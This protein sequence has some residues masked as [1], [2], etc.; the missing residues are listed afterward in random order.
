MSS[1]LQSSPNSAANSDATRPRRAKALLNAYYSLPASSNVSNAASPSS[2]VDPVSELDRQGFDAKRYFDKLVHTGELSQEA[3]AAR[4]AALDLEIQQLDS[5]LQSLV[6]DN[7]KQFTRAAGVISRMKEGIIEQLEPDFDNL[8]EHIKNMT[9]YEEVAESGVESNCIKLEEIIKKQQACHKLE[10]LFGLP[11]TLSRHLHSGNYRSAADIFQCCEPFLRRHREVASFDDVLQASEKIVEELKSALEIRIKKEDQETPAAARDAFTLLR[12]KEPIDKVGR[13]FL[14]GR[15]AVLKGILRVLSKPEFSS[16]VDEKDATSTVQDEAEAKAEAGAADRATQLQQDM[17]LPESRIFERATNIVSSRYLPTLLESVR[18]FS[19]LQDEEEETQTAKPMNNPI[20]E[21][22]TGT[23]DEAFEQLLSLLRKRQPPAQVVV[24]SLECCRNALSPLKDLLPSAISPLL[25]NFL[26]SVALDS[27]AGFFQKANDTVMSELDVLRGHC[28]ALEEQPDITSK[29]ILETIA[30]TE[31]AL[32]VAAFTA[33]SGSQPLLSLL[34]DASDAETRLVHELHRSITNFFMAIVDTCLYYIK[35]DPASMREKCGLPLE[36]SPSAASGTRRSSSSS[37]SS[38][39][40]TAAATAAAAAAA[41]AAAK[42][43]SPLAASLWQWSGIFGLSLV[44]M[45]R[46]FEVK[47]IAKVWAIAADLFGASAAVSVLTPPQSVVRATRLAAQ[48]VI[49]RYAE[50]RGHVLSNYF[51]EAME[52]HEWSLLREPR[53][54]FLVRKV[55]SEMSISN[56]QLSKVLADHRKATERRPLI[57]TKSAMEQEM[58]RMLAKKIQTYAPAP[59]NRNGVEVAILRISFK[60]LMEIA[61]EQRFAKFGL[62]QLQV[63]C[64]LLSNF[65]QNLVDFESSSALCSLL[66]EALH[67]AMNRCVEPELMSSSMVE[68]LCEK[69]GS[70]IQLA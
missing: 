38:P 67:S 54:S 4:S 59:F 21:F 46:H 6:H 27:L 28:A 20:V 9:E 23:L 17:H 15:R 65:A 11:A 55:V 25:R 47:V 36:A 39:A 18:A 43:A 60:A 58:E 69:N 48:A 49:T 3:V 51:R 66:S 56:G 31:Q 57:L 8:E 32:L 70:D 5:A 16:T 30:K 45:G 37:S 26:Q 29:E 42:N 63:D 68:A 35:E 41:A 40:A 7:Y 10:V 13:T 61:R 33:L 14:A 12:L 53:H 52:G 24:S 62:Q 1:S 50:I 44:R 2:T 64:A 19:A 22:V 34:Q